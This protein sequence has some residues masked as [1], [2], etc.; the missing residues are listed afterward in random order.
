[1]LENHGTSAGNLTLRE[2]AVVGALQARLSVEE[3]A[4]RLGTSEATIKEHVA[5][6]YRKARLRTIQDGM[7]EYFSSLAEWQEDSRL[8]T[9]RQML[10]AENVR[11]LHLH[12]LAV[13]KAWTGAGQAFLWVIINGHDGLRLMGRSGLLYAVRS[14]GVVPV[15]ATQPIAMV[16]ADSIK[17]EEWAV[18]ASAEAG[19]LPMEGE[20]I[21][22]A[23]AHGGGRWMALLTNLP[24]GWAQ[25]E[26]VEMAL[27]LAGMAATVAE[28]WAEPLKKLAA[29]TGAGT[30]GA[31]RKRA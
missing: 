5:A 31:G 20:V 12:L 14:D 4:M 28:S 3:I 13:L 25:I 8:R 22:L 18:V 16:G 10:H 11:D 7:A 2:H 30:D 24:D 29:S 6:I 23:V 17:S 21:A 27:T 1:M 19:S 26:A 9:L 15:I